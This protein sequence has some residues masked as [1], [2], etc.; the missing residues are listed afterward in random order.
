MM[1]WEG[2]LG[3]EP[4]SVFGHS[5]RLDGKNWLLMVTPSIVLAISNF[6]CTDR[7]MRSKT[8]KMNSWAKH[9]N[10]IQGTLNSDNP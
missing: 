10:S 5:E 7:A 8:G 4:S 6:L 1:E 2:S 9:S 3:R